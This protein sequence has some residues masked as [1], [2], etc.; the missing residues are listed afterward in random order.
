M[1][2]QPVPLD[3]SCSI[4][5]SALLE[6]SQYIYNPAILH[7]GL[8]ITHTQREDQSQKHYP[9][10]YEYAGPPAFRFRTETMLL[11]RFV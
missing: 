2:V 9:E 4:R 10:K 1:K 8:E 5:V 7:L 11:F 3:E 6:I